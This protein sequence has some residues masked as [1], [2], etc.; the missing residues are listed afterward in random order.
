MIENHEMMENILSLI[1]NGKND[2]VMKKCIPFFYLDNMIMDDVSLKKLQDENTI[3]QLVKNSMEGRYS[4]GIGDAV[5]AEI[6]KKL[7]E[8]CAKHG[9]EYQKNIRIHV[10]DRA[11]SFVLESSAKLNLIL[12]VSYSVTTSSS[13]G[14]KKEVAR[15]TIEILKKERSKNKN[16]VYVNF[17]DG[18]GWFGRQSDLKEI[19]RCSDYVLNFKN[20]DLLESI[21]DSHIDEWF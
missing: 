6:E 19:Y 15:K 21:I 17:L 8:V 2:D 4:N 1:W 13:Q 5:L 11:V 16:I 12:D 3:R 18:A 9:L 14:R 10:L 7:K 20:I